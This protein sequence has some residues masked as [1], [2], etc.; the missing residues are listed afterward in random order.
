V[1]DIIRSYS[2]STRIEKG[3]EILT[4]KEEITGIVASRKKR[5]LKQF[6]LS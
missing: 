3:I 2:N 6:C 1:N 4:S 5:K